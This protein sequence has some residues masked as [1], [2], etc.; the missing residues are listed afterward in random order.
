LGA[1]PGIDQRVIAI[2]HFHLSCDAK[3][4]NAQA[5]PEIDDSRR[6]AKA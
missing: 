1:H 3:A 5:K 6:R 4:S 2:A